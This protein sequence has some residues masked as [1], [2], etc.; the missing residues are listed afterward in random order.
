MTR[1]KAK[2]IRAR[3]LQGKPVH[4]IDAELAFERLARRT[5]RKLVLPKLAPEVKERANQ[6]LL[7]RLGE[8]LGWTRASA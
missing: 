8:A 3:Q 5:R 4:P 1:D 6:V 2:R 7:Q